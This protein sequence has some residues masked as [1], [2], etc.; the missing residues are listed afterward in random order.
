MLPLSTQL[1]RVWRIPT[2]GSKTKATHFLVSTPVLVSKIAT[3]IIKL[4]TLQYTPRLLN[5]SISCRNS[6][7]V[8]TLRI[9]KKGSWL[10]LNSDALQR[11]CFTTVI[12]VFFEITIKSSDLNYKLRCSYNNFYLIYQQGNDITVKSK[13]GKTWFLFS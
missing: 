8:R 6:S 9:T 1:R 13:V 4:C 5:R 2:F 11:T 12:I 10:V 7:V 3:A